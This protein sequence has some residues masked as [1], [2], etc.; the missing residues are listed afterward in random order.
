MRETEANVHR[1]HEVVDIADARLQLD[2]QH[3]ARGGVP[4]DDVDHATFSVEGE[5]D[6]G[7]GNPTSDGR[8]PPRHRLVKPRVPTIQH[9][10]EPGALPEDRSIESSAKRCGI[11]SDVA[12]A[13]AVEATGLDQDRNIPRDPGADADVLLTLSA[14][15]P[16]GSK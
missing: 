14:S 16:E 1:H 2:Q 15:E 11:P 3:R 7:H 5:R 9:S 6:L 12:E 8:E 13:D 10:I 4:S